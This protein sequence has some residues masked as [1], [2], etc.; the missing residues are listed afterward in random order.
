MARDNDYEMTSCLPSLS[1]SIKVFKGIEAREKTVTVYAFHDAPVNII[2]MERDG[3]VIRTET[4]N[5]PG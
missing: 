5:F 1:E 2:W 4:V 3:T